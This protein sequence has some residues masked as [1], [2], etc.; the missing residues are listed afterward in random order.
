MT[1]ASRSDSFD[2]TITDNSSI[3]DC[4]DVTNYS[5]PLGHLNDIRLT[6]DEDTLVELFG[7]QNNGYAHTVITGSP[8]SKVGDEFYLNVQGREV[9]VNITHTSQGVPEDCEEKK[10]STSPPKS[11]PTE[12]TCPS[13]FIILIRRHSNLL[14]GSIGFLLLLGVITLITFHFIGDKN[15]DIT[16]T[17]YKTTTSTSTTSTSRTSTNHHFIHY[18][19]TRENWGA[20][21]ATKKIPALINPVS[22]VIVKHTN[23]DMCVNVNECY[24]KMKELQ[25]YDIDVEKLPNIRYNFVIGADWNVYEGRGWN[26]QNSQRND[27]I[28]IAFMG[29][30]SEIVPGAIMVTTG[31]W[32]I[33]IGVNSG[34]LDTNVKV[35]CHNQTESIDSPGEYLYREVVKWKYYSDEIIGNFST[36]PPKSAPSEKTSPSRVTILIR[37]HSKLISFS[38][39]ILLLLGIITFTIL[40]FVT[41]STYETTTSTP[42]TTTKHHIIHNLFTRENWGARD[43]G[44]KIPA[45]IT[46]VSLVIIKHTKTDMC[47]HVSDCFAEMKQLQNYDVGV[48]KLPDLRYNFVIGADWNVYEGRGWKEQNSQRNDSIDIAFMGNYNEVVPGEITVATGPWLIDIGVNS[49]Y[50][51]ANVRVVCHNQTENTDSPGEYL[52]REVVKWK[53]YSNEIIGNYSKEKESSRGRKL[54]FSASLGILVLIL[55]IL[56]TIWLVLPKNKTGGD[57]ITTV[58]PASTPS[59]RTIIS[60]EIWGAA[61]PKGPYVSIPA[62]SVV[63]IK[64]TGGLTC[65]DFSS[66]CLRIREIQ[67]MH[68]DFLN[69]IDI[70]YNFLIGGDRR[71]YSGRGWAVANE[72]IR[73]DTVDIAFIGNFSENVPSSSMLLA[74]DRIILQA[75]DKG[76]NYSRHMVVNHNQT[77]PTDSP[78]AFL[79]AKVTEEVN[80]YSSDVCYKVKKDGGVVVNYS[81]PQK[82]G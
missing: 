19:F 11:T 34:Y 2:G 61:E 22:L 55:I 76:L 7:R 33:D 28:D 74:L 14:I 68:M 10:V 39:G 47:T 80:H 57:I 64:H 72:D 54:I 65:T 79:F 62:P 41:T 77:E 31:P 15:E 21:D 40:H 23:T 1:L 8:N 25:N 73:N 6:K 78:G 81:C 44:E 63:V 67:K 20:R 13:R 18:L 43:S 5:L 56:V 69:M 17:T 48:E 53:Y 27:S 35:V 24:A 60:R 4:K 75:P 32:L 51:D 38:I 45:L 50:L 71:I 36:N 58:P 12:K 66:C 49:G 59:Y 42:S 16:P 52:Y 29:N 70:S 37:R 3:D 9:N 26:E 30:Y 46:P 82:V